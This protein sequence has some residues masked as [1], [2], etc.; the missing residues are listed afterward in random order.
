M[1]STHPG[2]ALKAG[3]V[4]KFLALAG[5]SD[6]LFREILVRKEAVRKAGELKI[7]ASD[8]ELQEFADRFRLARGLSSSKDTFDFLRR[9]GLTEE[10]FADY[11]EATVLTRKLKDHL[12]DERT[13]RDYFINNRSDLDLTRVSTITVKDEGLASEI[14]LQVT[15]EGADFHALAR[16]FSREEGTKDAGGF[17]G[18]V[19]RRHFS[20]EISAKVF[21]AARGEVV[22]PFPEEGIWR[23]YFVEERVRT[24][25]NDRTRELIKQ[26]I[27]EDW[28]SSS[29]K[30]Q[31]AVAP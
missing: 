7:A 21:N 31:I 13:I 5:Q 20:P 25:L 28:A 4:V 17:I 12:A 23:L 11:C 30:G 27:F 8:E 10:D 18:S 9:N 3:E 1:A 24:E 19:S 22:G 14:V 26:R 29:L 15:E 6:L 16:K 2:A